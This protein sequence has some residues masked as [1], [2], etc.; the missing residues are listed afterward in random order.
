MQPQSPA[1][2]ATPHAVDACDDDSEE[3]TTAAPEA[4]EPAESEGAADRVSRRQSS[5]S[6]IQNKS[7]RF[8]VVC[9]GCKAI[10]SVPTIDERFVCRECN[11]V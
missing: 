3:A 10:N 2:V 7:E 6:S 9:G 5:C 1:D 4:G 8:A 11:Q